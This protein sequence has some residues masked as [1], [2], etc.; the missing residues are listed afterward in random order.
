MYPR[1][2]EHRVREALSDTRI[3]FISGPRQ[4]GKTTLAKIFSSENRPYYSL[5]D[6][7]LRKTAADN[8]V[9]FIRRLDCAI[10]DEVHRVPELVLAIK[11][12]VDADPRAGR[13]LLTGSANF[14]KFSQLGDSL[15]GR[16]SMI[17]L[18]PLAQSELIDT[19]SSF[20]TDAFA[21]KVPLSKDNILL[22]DHLIDVVLAGGYPEVLQ[23]SS[24]HRRF[25]WYR[26]YVDA[27]I[28]R[29]VYEVSRIEQLSV[30]PRL[31]QALAEFSGKLAN[32]SKVGAMVG[33][34]HVTTQKYVNLLEQVF[35]I[36]TLQPWSTNRLKRIAKSPKL[37]FLDSG[38][39]AAQKGVSKNRLDHDRSW[40]GPI[41]ESFVLS[42]LLKLASWSGEHYFFSHFRQ[43][44]LHEVDIVIEDLRGDVVGIEVKASATVSKKDFAGLRNLAQACG[45]KFKLGVVLYDHDI[46]IAFDDQ[47]I[48]APISSLWS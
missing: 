34:N 32:F 18:F 19:K 14:W 3:V 4:S 41:L 16:I 12:S 17:Q 39:L 20:L 15:A 26:D 8:P 1:F 43:H 33:L 10:I 2:V 27:I 11:A 6:P 37:H 44:N 9:G 28:Q 35:L 42:E 45:K 38:L 21:Q 31:L 40:F 22:D 23:R 36:H 25:D 30:M 29:D 13:F 7:T 24:E 47:F 48:A 46:T 5:D